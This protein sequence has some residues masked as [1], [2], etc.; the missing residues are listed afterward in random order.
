MSSELSFRKPLRPVNEAIS[1]PLWSVMIPTYNCAKYLRSTLESVLKQDLGPDLMQIMVIDDCSTKDDPEAVVREV[2]QGRIEFYRQ[3][4]NVGLTKNFRTSLEM[5]RGYLVH[6]LHGDDQ[7]RPGFYKKL[8]VAFETNPEV[9]AAFCRTIYMDENDHWTGLAHLELSNSGILPKEWL[10]RLAT[11]CCIHTPSIVV[12][13]EV[14]EKIGG[15]DQ[16]L[17]Y[18]GEDWEMWART[19]MTYPIWY[20]VEPLSIYRGAPGSITDRNN[21]NGRRIEDVYSAAQII[22]SYFPEVLPKAIR[23]IPYR[24]CAFSALGTAK[25]LLKSGDIR[26]S[27]P[28]IRS[29]LR[30]QTS[31]LVLRSLLGILILHLPIA[32]LKSIFQPSTSV[33]NSKT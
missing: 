12:R 9:G 14:Y 33:L 28:H 2:G 15:F 3:P 7:V 16:R 19:A 17:N 26:L 5:S 31:Y 30:Y 6:Q 8:Q 27:I 29:A 1:R 10:Q 32:L 23:A 24:N 13:R 25:V 21:L 4:K 18:A 20:E 11:T 22:H